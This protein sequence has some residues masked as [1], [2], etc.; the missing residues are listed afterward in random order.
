VVLR[1]W[2]W[3]WQASMFFTMTRIM[4]L[5]ISIWFCLW[6]ALRLFLLFF[7]HYWFYFFRVGYNKFLAILQAVLFFI[8]ELTTFI[9]ALFLGMSGMPRRIN[10]YPVYFSGWHSLSSLGHGLVVLSLFVFLVLILESKYSSRKFLYANKYSK[11]IPFFA[12]RHSAY[13]MLIT[14]L[15][16]KIKTKKILSKPVLTSF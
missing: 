1:V 7:F 4:L 16:T 2:F 9:P 5:D 3:V 6:A 11:G 12:N 8:G 15:R 10:D 13:L 14:Q